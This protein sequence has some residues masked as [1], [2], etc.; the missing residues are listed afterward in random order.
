MADRSTTSDLP[1]PEGSTDRP[2]LSA[3]SRWWS[4]ASDSSTADAVLGYESALPWTL[5]EDASGDRSP[6]QY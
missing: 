5:G 3:L 1:T 2:Q 6:T 4:T